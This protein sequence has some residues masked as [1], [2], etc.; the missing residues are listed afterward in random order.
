MITASP[1]WLLVRQSDGATWTI[2][3]V[4]LV[5]SIICWTVALY[6]WV[7]LNN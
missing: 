4:L 1:L 5:M 7:Q 2:L 6:K 3:L